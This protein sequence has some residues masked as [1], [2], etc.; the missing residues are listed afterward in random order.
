LAA[1]QVLRALEE[2]QLDSVKQVMVAEKVVD[3]DKVA[4]DRAAAAEA[5]AEN[6]QEEEVLT[7]LVFNPLGL[8]LRL[9]RQVA[10]VERDLLNTAQVAAEAQ[11]KQEL[12]DRVVPEDQVAQE[13][14]MLFKL[15][16]CTK[17]SRNSSF[18]NRIWFWRRRKWRPKQNR[19]IWFSWNCSSEVPY[20][21]AKYW[22]EVNSANEVIE[23]TIFQDDVTTAEKAAAVKPLA[24]SNNQYVEYFLDGGSRKI[25][26]STGK[27]D[28]PSGKP[29]GYSYWDEDA[30][31]WQTA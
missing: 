8:D 20:L 2:T 15:R 27:W 23:T 19:W 24:D 5:A 6:R 13:F 10:Q 22:A 1:E 16:L 14:K 4:A 25:R 30:N 21:M 12:V 7:N 17:R 29:E 9:V 31:T 18:R 3:F 28:E 26:A 11:V